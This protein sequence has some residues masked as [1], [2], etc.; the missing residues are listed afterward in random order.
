MVISALRYTFAD[1]DERYNEHLRPIVMEMLTSMLN[2]DDLENRRLALTT[3]SSAAHNKP[4]LIQ[5]HLAQLMPLAIKETIIKP[6]LVREVA[7]GPFKHKVDDGLELRKVSHRNMD[8]QITSFPAIELVLC[9][10]VCV[11][12]ATVLG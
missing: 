4:D 12:S 3:L 11:W 5:P 6:E 2:E 1:A 8:D 7:M 10:S 9:L